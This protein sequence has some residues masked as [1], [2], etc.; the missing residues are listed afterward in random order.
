MHRHGIY[1][2]IYFIGLAPGGNPVKKFLSEKN[3]IVSKV[4]DVALIQL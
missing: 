2:L 1:D 3:Q 4:E